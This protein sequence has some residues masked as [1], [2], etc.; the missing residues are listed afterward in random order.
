MSDI[1]KNLIITA[2]RERVW[3]GLTDPTAI[4]EWMQ[5][6]TVT[7]ELRPGGNYALFGG[8]TTGHFTHVTAPALLEYT[9]RQDTW[10]ATWEDSLVRWELHAEGSSTRLYLIHSRFPN[11]EERDSHDEGWDTY[12]LQPMQEWLENG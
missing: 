2:P 5:D 9:W 1:R 6:D 4:S 3:A 8:A 11:H 7:V 10:P 12:W